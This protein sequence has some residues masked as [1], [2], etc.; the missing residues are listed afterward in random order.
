M[1]T[2]TATDDADIVDLT[3]PTKPPRFQLDDDVFT[4][5]RK[6]PVGRL[7]RLIGFQKQMSN[8]SETYD[9]E[10]LYNLLGLV[11]PA[12]SVEKIR[13]RADSLE[14]PIDHIDLLSAIDHMMEVWGMRPTQPSSDSSTTSDDG[15]S[16]TTST[17]GPPAAG[18][19]LKALLQTDSS[20]SPIDTSSSLL[21]TTTAN[22]S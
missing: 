11:M 15:T 13:E 2:P 10:P 22:G 16:G 21:T 5:A 19:T 3:R 18:S 6:V 8:F 14:N 20:T 12:E 17:D 1:T 7:A 4:F 9:L